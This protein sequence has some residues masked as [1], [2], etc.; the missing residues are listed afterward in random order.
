MPFNAKAIG[1]IRMTRQRRSSSYPIISATKLRTQ[2]PLQEQIRDAKIDTS[3]VPWLNHEG[4]ISPDNEAY[5]TI[6]R[7]GRM[8]GENY[9]NMGEY[10]YNVMSEFQMADSCRIHI[11][12]KNSQGAELEHWLSV[13]KEGDVFRAYESGEPPLEIDAQRRAVLQKAFNEKRPVLFDYDLGVRLA[14]NNL[15]MNDRSCEVH[16]LT[17]NSGTGSLAVMPFYYRDS[18][19]PSGIVE[20][21]GN[22]GCRGSG[23]GGLA[24]SV[25]TANAAIM[26]AMQI[27]Y[28]ITHRF[29]AITDLARFVDYEKDLR[30]GISQ[31]AD[32]KIKSLHHVMIDVDNFKSVNGRFG[33]DVGDLVLRGVAETIKESVRSND[34][35]Y[36]VGGEEFAV[37]LVDVTENGALAIAERV[38]E[39]VEKMKHDSGAGPVG[40]TVS[41]GICRVNDTMSRIIGAGNLMRKMDDTMIGFVYDQARRSTDKGLKQAKEGGK[42]RV[43]VCDPDRITPITF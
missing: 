43:C 30:H 1:R 39:N 26:A 15:D 3:R 16:P 42:N 35:A 8:V 29:D 24:R 27:G 17:G 19:N 37:I 18:V 25:L 10:V 23:I 11:L 32:S 4:T 38:R 40:V 41:I 22:L 9:A 14:F 21:E 20:F 31:L 5:M 34:I 2:D 28:T 6:Y 33:H 36:R 7:I 13:V 12:P